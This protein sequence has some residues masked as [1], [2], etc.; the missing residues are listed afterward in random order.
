MV[1]EGLSH[2]KRLVDGETDKKKLSLTS[3]TLRGYV[4]GLEF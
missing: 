3:V 2:I 4:W 1:T